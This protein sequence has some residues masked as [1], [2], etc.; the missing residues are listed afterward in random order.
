[1]YCG[2]ITSV[3]TIGGHTS[4]NYARFTPWLRI[5]SLPICLSNGWTNRPFED[6]VSWC[7]LLAERYVLMMKLENRLALS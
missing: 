4:A 1:M 5:M 2:A 6:K 7:I 3:K